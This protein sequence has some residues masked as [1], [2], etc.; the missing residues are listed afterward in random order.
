ML[1]CINLFKEEIVN[2]DELDVNNKFKILSLCSDG[3]IGKRLSAM[4]FTRGTEGVIDPIQVKILGYNVSIRKSEAKCVEVEK[5][6]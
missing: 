6:D 2:I 1:V 4:G 3:E 5:L